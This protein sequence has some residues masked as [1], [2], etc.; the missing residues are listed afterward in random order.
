[1]NKS[2]PPDTQWIAFAQS[3]RIGQGA[4]RQ[5]AAL[6]KAFSDQKPNEPAL[7]FDAHTSQPIEIDLR[8][9]LATVLARLPAE[10]QDETPPPTSVPPTRSPGRPKLGV[11]AREVTL[12]P[13]HWEWLSAQPGGASVSLRKLVEQ[14]LRDGKRQDQ[15]RQ[16]RESAYRFMSAMAGN[17]PGFEEA[18]R[19]L[20]AGNQTGFRESVAG[21]PAD[22]RAHALT[23]AQAATSASSDDS[24]APEPA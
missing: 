7:V 20:F 10:A 16:A 4:P 1:M 2:T 24:P 21:W 17:E 12:L 3:T 6:L 22:V 13:R 9:S 18:T 19:A 14:A 15:V 23:L 8:G 11:T 5:V